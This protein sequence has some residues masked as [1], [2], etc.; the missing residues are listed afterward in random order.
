MNTHL[1]YGGSSCA[2]NTAS[3][4]G[5]TGYPGYPGYPDL[6]LEPDDPGTRGTPV[7][8]GAHSATRRTPG[9]IAAG[10]SLI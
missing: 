4:F 1:Y 5:G 3:E 8:P 6:Y 9:Q 10:D 2:P 7:Q